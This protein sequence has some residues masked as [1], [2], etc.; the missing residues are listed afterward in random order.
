MNNGKIKGVY[1]IDAFGLHCTIRLKH[2]AIKDLKVNRMVA[3]LSQ[4]Y[5]I[6]PMEYPDDAKPIESG[7]PLLTETAIKEWVMGLERVWNNP[8]A[9]CPACKKPVSLADNETKAKCSSC[10]KEWACEELI[11]TSRKSPPTQTVSGDPAVSIQ[12]ATPP[13]I[14]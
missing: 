14:Q 11:A 12:P 7:C 6:Q 2:W 3:M 8:V 10:N 4:G 5:A 1:P 9:L 13:R